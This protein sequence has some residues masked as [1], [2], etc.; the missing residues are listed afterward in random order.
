MCVQITDDSNIKEAVKAMKK[1][2]KNPSQH[3]LLRNRMDAVNDQ[4]TAESSARK[5]G[6]IEALINLVTKGI[7]APE[8]AAKE[9]GISIQEFASKLKQ[10]QIA[11]QEQN[12]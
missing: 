4:I 2:V 12:T 5:E 9:A 11:K 10:R 8:V 6:M 3:E 1:I 7:V